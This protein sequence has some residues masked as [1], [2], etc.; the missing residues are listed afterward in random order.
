[1]TVVRLIVIAIGALAVV[2]AV[3]LVSRRWNDQARYGGR[4]A[5]LVHVFSV[6]AFGAFLIA[7][8]TVGLPVAS[9]YVVIG[10]GLADLMVGLFA[11]RRKP[12]R[13]DLKAG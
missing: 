6:T 11:R 9:A 12:G 13:S 2:D 7:A 8:A 10:I 4:A 3:V 1:M 5:F